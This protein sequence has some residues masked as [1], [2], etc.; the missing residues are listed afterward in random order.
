M[1]ILM[2]RWYTTLY[3]L[4][5]LDHLFEFFLFILK[6]IQVK[7]FTTVLLLYRVWAHV[8]VST[9]EINKNKD[10]TCK[11][12]AVV[13]HLTGCPSWILYTQKEFKN[14]KTNGSS[15]SWKFATNARIHTLVYGQTHM[16]TNYGIKL[17]PVRVL[18]SIWPGST[19]EDQIWH[20]ILQIGSINWAWW[21]M[22]IIKQCLRFSSTQDFSSMKVKAY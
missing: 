5:L 20:L 2:Y 22:K 17:K 12:E 10:N 18:A 11:G 1:Y 6:P 16:H 19:T 21:H 15:S 7:I 8:T 9:A 13:L 3:W 4:N 14:C